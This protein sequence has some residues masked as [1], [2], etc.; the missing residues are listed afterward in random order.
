MLRRVA[1]ELRT[2]RV[3]FK[4]VVRWGLVLG[5]GAIEELADRIEKG[6]LSAVDDD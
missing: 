4:G 3:L 1:G 6:P 2:V 5:A